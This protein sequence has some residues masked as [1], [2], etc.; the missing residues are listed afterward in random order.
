MLRSRSDGFSFQLHTRAVAV[1]ATLMFVMYAERWLDFFAADGALSSFRRGEP[2][3]RLSLLHQQPTLWW[4]IGICS[5]AGLAWERTRRISAVLLWC[6]CTSMVFMNWV[7]LSGEDRLLR[8][9]LPLLILLP[10]IQVASFPAW[11]LL[12]LRIQVAAVYVFTGISKIRADYSWIDGSAVYYAWN[13]DLFSRISAEQSLDLAFLSPLLSS[14][15][16]VFESSFV[17]ALTNRWLRRL[18]VVVMLG[19]HMGLMLTMRNLELFNLMML[20]GLGLFVERDDLT[21]LRTIFRVRNR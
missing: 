21:L 19:F 12:L 18:Y 13:F 11:Q 10:R 5:S 14:L 3:Y 15:T 20:A 6:L 9:Y 17:L 2:W 1:V 8:H 4:Y 16:I 7:A